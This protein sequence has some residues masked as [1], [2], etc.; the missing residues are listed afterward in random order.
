MPVRGWAQEAPDSEAAASTD[1]TGAASEGGSTPSGPTSEQAAGEQASDDEA[2]MHFRLGRAYFDSGRFHDAAR[3]F[4]LAY[5]ESGRPALL[6]NLYVSHR[7]AGNLRASVEALRAYLSQADN[8][9]NRAQLAARLENMEGLLARQAGVH[10]EVHIDRGPEGGE[11]SEA[12]ASAATAS[13]TETPAAHGGGG[14]WMPGFLIAG[15]GG[16]LV[17]VGAVLGGVALADKSILEE[18]FNCDADGVCDPG[19][20]DLASRGS[21]LAGAADGLLFGGLAVAA[22]GVV[23]AFVLAESGDDVSA[24]AACTADGCTAQLGGRF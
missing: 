6:Y 16:L 19:F 2:R 8:I 13:G 18:D 11:P 7:D 21:A 23:L 15:G 20:E 1:R 10:T 9:E 4:Q 12:D 14:P 17:L 5:D 3:E 24:A 22:T